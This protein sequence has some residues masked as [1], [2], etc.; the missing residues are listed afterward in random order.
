MPKILL[1]SLKIS[2]CHKI[3]D[4]KAGVN[5]CSTVTTLESLSLECM[6]PRGEVQRNKRL[7]NVS[8]GFT[9]DPNSS[10]QDYHLKVS[11]GARCFLRAPDL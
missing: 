5:A 10:V 7:R 3:S 1:K 6:V 2:F 9:H 11:E 4:V 8:M